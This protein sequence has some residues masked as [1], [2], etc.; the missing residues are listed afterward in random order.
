M[1]IINLKMNAIIEHCCRLLYV[2]LC[3]QCY[4]AKCGCEDI[5]IN[6]KGKLDTSWT[7][8]AAKFSGVY[9]QNRILFFVENINK[10]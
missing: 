10:C 7:K 8:A 1:S 4:G 3:I 2:Q 5:W 6:I 9:P